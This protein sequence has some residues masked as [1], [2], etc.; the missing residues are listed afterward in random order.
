VE[1]TGAFL[2]DFTKSFK[3][4]AGETI[5]QRHENRIEVDHRLEV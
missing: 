1:L 4:G 3:S 5:K 2:S